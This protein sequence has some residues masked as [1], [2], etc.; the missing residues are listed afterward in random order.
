MGGTCSITYEENYYCIKN[1][2]IYSIGCDDK[3]N[4]V[5]FYQPLHILQFN[6]KKQDNQERTART[7]Q[8]CRDRKEQLQQDSWDRSA[9]QGGRNSTVR[10]GQRLREER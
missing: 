6:L 5:Q 1:L 7:G 8:D 4:S 2:E 9:G 10:T 3:L